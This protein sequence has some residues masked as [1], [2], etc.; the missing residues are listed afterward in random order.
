LSAG[1]DGY[2]PW[3]QFVHEHRTALIAGVLLVVAMAILV[4]T[5]VSVGGG[6]GGG[7]Y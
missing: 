5:L 4:L 3:M 1:G 6:T 2:M 7:G